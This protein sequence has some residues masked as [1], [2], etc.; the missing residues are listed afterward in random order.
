MAGW[1]LRPAPARLRAMPRLLFVTH[2]F[3]PQALIGARRCR[4]ISI[5]LRDRGWDVD[6]LTV[7]ELYA[8][9]TDDR[10]LQGLDGI[11]ITRTH[12]VDPR[13][14]VAGLRSAAPENPASQQAAV[15][16]SP[17][18]AEPSTPPLSA[19]LKKAAGAVLRAVELP[20]AYIGWLIPALAAA[21]RR[22]QPD[23]VLSS[24][25][26]FSNA[27][28]AAAVARTRRVPLALDYRDP[29]AD[30]TRAAALS[31]GRFELERRLEAWCLEAAAGVTATTPTIA[32]LLR[33]RTGKPATVVF[34]AADP[35]DFLGLQPRRFARPTVL[36]TGAL[37]GGRRIEALMDAMADHG[38]DVDL[39]YM[40]G[41]VARVVAAA[42][43]RGLGARVGVQ[44]N[45]PRQEAFAA[46]L[47]ARANICLVAPEHH[48]QVPGKLF[49]QLGCGR[50]TLVVGPP[51]CDAAKVIEGQAGAAFAAID[52]PADI[53]AAL[54]SLPEASRPIGAPD[55]FSVAETMDTMHT[56]LRAALP[57][58]AR[59][60]RHHR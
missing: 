51:G 45:S 53:A 46:M 11:S 60:V 36:Y 13:R 54:A 6:V 1:Q 18:A 40:G 34:N 41:A 57:P 4:R 32:A 49:E 20:D 22:P 58:G 12:A 25:P 42:E 31:A 2:V 23:L 8:T 16:S 33:A 30:A 38:A 56:A 7:R 27:V 48:A 55:G 19:R 9:R 37:Y 43:A 14:W 5:G 35:A 39:H 15:L 17:A 29:W 21:A 59:H 44:G 10:T 47:G 50:P 28:I 24:L 26:W 3:P 52:R